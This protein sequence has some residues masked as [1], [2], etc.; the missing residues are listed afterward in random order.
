MARIATLPDDNDPR[1]L[2]PRLYFRRRKYVI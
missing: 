1:F 2:H